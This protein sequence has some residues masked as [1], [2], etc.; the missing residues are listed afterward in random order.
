M[1]QWIIRSIPHGVPIEL[2]LIPASAKN[3]CSWC[4]GS[5]DQ[6]LMLEPLSYFSFQPVLHNW[7]I[8]G[9]GMCYPVCGVVHIKGLI[10]KSSPCGSNGFPLLLSEQSFT[11]LPMPY[12]HK[13]NVL[14]L[15]LNKTFHSFLVWMIPLRTA[16]IWLECC[17]SLGVAEFH[18]METPQNL[19]V[20]FS[21]LVP[22]SLK[23]MN[24]VGQPAVKNMWIKIFLKRVIY[25]YGSD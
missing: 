23:A 9:S 7:C 12:N 11:I 16:W 1:V 24:H 18:L 19:A 15:S 17:S 2:F 25:T 6:S 10:R 3:T 14:S 4:N 22:I 5:S 8:K 21:Q 13:E 20:E